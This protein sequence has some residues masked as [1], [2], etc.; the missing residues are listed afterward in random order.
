MKPESLITSKIIEYCHPLPLIFVTGATKTGKV[1]IARKLA[2]ELDRQLLISD[3]YIE[4]YG[5]KD[6][7]DMLERDVND[8]Y[9]AVLPIIVE[10]ILTYRLLRR[11]ATKGHY[12]PDVLIKTECNEQ[13]IQYFYQREEPNK[14]LN[15]VFGFNRGLEK[16]YNE[17]IELIQSQGQTIKQLKLNTSI[18]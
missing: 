11:M 3:D 16:I 10:G 12:L 9:Y 13:T 18:F 5:Q 8:C 17:S 7:L 14:N 6:A 2:S 15:S 4:K 1:A